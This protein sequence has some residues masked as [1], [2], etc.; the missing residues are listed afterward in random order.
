[1]RLLSI[2][3]N[4]L[5]RRKGRTLFQALGLLIGI[6]AVVTL[7]AVTT[8]MRA[9]LEKKI[10]EFG[11]NM[12]IVPKA[13]DLTLSYGGITLPNTGYG[14][15]YL[16]EEDAAKIRTIKDAASINIVAPK[17]LGVV[18]SGGRKLLM[19]GVRFKDEL[20]VK[21]WWKLRGAKPKKPDEVIVGANAASKLGVRPG[22]DLSLS[23]KP[24][25]VAAVLRSTGSSED[26]LIFAD[27]G[28]S[29]KLLG[30]PG[31]VSMIEVAAWCS[32]CPIERLVAQSAYVLPNAKI[33]AVKQ[34]AAARKTTVDLV[35]KFSIGIAAAVLAVG[36]LIVFTTMMASVSERTREIGVFRAIG[37]RQSHVLKMFVFEIFA[38]SLI[39]GMLG[40][41]IGTGGAQ[42]LAPRLAGAPVKIAWDPRVAAMAVALALVIGLAA[43]FY[44]AR[45]ASRLDPVEALR[46]L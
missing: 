40:F 34:A 1:M 36:A 6:A 23:D 12:I 15:K 46:S 25:R 4:N 8:A 16:D 33:T 20:A 37:F 7:I 2:S 14:A 39:S 42:A 38:L 41:V 31:K 44:P 27:L 35:T 13:N 30:V 5:T 21:K 43:S 22:E 24:F 26:D 11:T 9:D 17:L 10:D 18:N 29:Q 28:G 3:L 45:R 19:V 32:S